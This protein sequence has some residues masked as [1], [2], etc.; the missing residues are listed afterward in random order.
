M[1][2]L[3]VVVS[4]MSGERLPAVQRSAL[5]FWLLL[6][7]PWAHEAPT[8]TDPFSLTSR[9]R[10]PIESASVPRSCFPDSFVHRNVW[11]GSDCPM[12]AEPSAL[13][14]LASLYA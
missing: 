4:E 12:T 10:V 7:P 2:A 6:S 14:S 5:G 8:T 1:A 3:A 9:A 11:V 13:M